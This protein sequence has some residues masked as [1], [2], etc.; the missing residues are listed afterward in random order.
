M[1]PTDEYARLRKYFIDSA[2]EF[3]DD[4][5]LALLQSYGIINGDDLN[6]VNF[7]DAMR[8]WLQQRLNM[9]CLLQADVFDKPEPLKPIFKVYDII[10]E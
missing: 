8:R 5:I 3:L 1:I 7:I 4:N 9:S 2:C 10:T 6:Y